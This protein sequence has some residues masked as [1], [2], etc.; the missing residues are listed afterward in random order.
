MLSIWDATSCQRQ[1]LVR[2]HDERTTGVA[3]HPHA[4][5]SGRTDDVLALAT[6][7]VDGS[8]ALLGGAGKQ[9]R[10]LQV[11]GAAPVCPAAGCWA[12]R[13]RWLCRGSQLHPTCRRTVRRPS[14]RPLALCRRATPT[15]WAASPSTPWAATWRPPA[16][17]RPGACGTARQ[18]PAFWSRRATAAPSTRSRSSMTARWRAAWAS[19][20]WVRR[21]CRWRCRWRRCWCCWPGQGKLLWARQRCSR[22]AAPGS[23]GPCTTMHRRAPPCTAR[24]TSYPLPAAP[25][26]WVGFQV[27]HQQP[28]AAARLLAPRQLRQAQ[29]QRTRQTCNQQACPA[30]PHPSAPLCTAAKPGNP[31]LPRR[32]P[33]LGL[34]H[35]PQHPQPAG[36]REAVP[37]HRLQPQR[38]PRGHR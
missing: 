6:G 1:Q 7:G 33:H 11:R 30:C 10:R 34:P 27:P 35:R 2:T 37:G 26:H 23:A 32:R 16:S 17:T 9:L 24:T 19:T 15:A 22:A 14:P 20:R 3:W 8:A 28:L 31:P 38:L 5:A 4:S 36:P 29:P 21:R 13:L 18:A 25:R 12:A